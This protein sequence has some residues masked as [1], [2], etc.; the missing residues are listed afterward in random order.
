MV[1]ISPPRQTR[2]RD[3]RHVPA[4]A[5]ART[6]QHTVAL[7]RMLPSPFSER[8]LPLAVPGHER[9]DPRSALWGIIASHLLR[10]S[11]SV[12]M[13]TSLRGQNFFAIRKVAEV[14]PV[15]LASTVFRCPPADEPRL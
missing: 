12:E 4:E 3:P 14:Q 9:P 11:G 6:G 10:R 5:R 15:E 13:A 1:V 8:A 7:R 2:Q